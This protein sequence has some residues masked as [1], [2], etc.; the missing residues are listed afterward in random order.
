MKTQILRI[1]NSNIF[2]DPWEPRDNALENTRLLYVDLDVLLQVVA[3]QIEHEVVNVVETITDDDQRQLISQL[4]LLKTHT[5]LTDSWL[6]S[7]ASGPTSFL[8]DNKLHNI[9]NHTFF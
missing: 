8:Y 9:F 1:C 2:Q 6:Y 3:V 7:T 4:R 5:H